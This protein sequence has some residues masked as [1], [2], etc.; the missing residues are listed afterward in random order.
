LRRKDGG[1]GREKKKKRVIMGTGKGNP[2]GAERD[3]LLPK[4]EKDSKL[5]LKVRKRFFA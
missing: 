5:P 3:S 2:S 4:K 1:S